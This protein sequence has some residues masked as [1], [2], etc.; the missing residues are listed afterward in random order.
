MA[1][2]AASSARLDNLSLRDLEILRLLAQGRSL[3]EIAAALGIAYKTAANGC[4]ALK[5]K[6]GV[7]RT[8]E[9]ILLAADLTDLRQT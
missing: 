5:E 2:G 4:T 6:L 8:G 7:S 9:L 3:S 1:L